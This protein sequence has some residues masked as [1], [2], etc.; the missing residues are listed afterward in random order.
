[1]NPQRHHFPMDKTDR[2]HLI[3]I[4]LA[5][6]LF[7]TIALAHEDEDH[8][9][10]GAVILADHAEEVVLLA[11]LRDHVE[12]ARALA[13]SPNSEYLASGGE[14]LSV[15]L[16]HVASAGMVRA[17][18]LHAGY[19]TGV[20]FAPLDDT[21]W[22]LVSIGWDRGVIFQRVPVDNP[23]DAEIT[24]TFVGA[25]AVLLQV[26]FSPD[27]SQLAVTAGTGTLFLLDTTTITEI[28]RADLPALESTALVFSPDGALLAVAPGFPSTGVLVFDLSAG[29]ESPAFTLP[30]EHTV[31][32]LDF[33][34]AS[35]DDSPFR[36]VTV[37]DSGGLRLWEL[38]DDWQEL[39]SASMDDNWV[40]SA[41]YHPSGEL[42]ATASLEGIVELWDVRDP[43]E[44]QSLIALDGHDAFPVYDVAFSPDGTLLASAGG[45]KTI[46]L[47][48]LPL[49][50]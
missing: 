2:L 45:D 4:L 15:R 46:R 43:E 18:E 1:M 23:A 26:A 7:G 28:A 19:V 34:P 48:G 29:I 38:D 40:L 3:I 44:P 47:W 5:F 41:A 17:R 24:A 35:G 16:W 13:F 33:D 36:L 6:L 50:R 39:G 8:T 14:D 20:D 11:T 32:G 10:S 49:E 25:N 12:A 22:L 30:H 21:A 31:T 27:G 37:D 9:G 42:V